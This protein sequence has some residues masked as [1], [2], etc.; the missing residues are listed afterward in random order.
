LRKSF[1]VVAGAS[2][3]FLPTFIV[4][5]SRAGEVFALRVSNCIMT[6]DDNEPVLPA[7]VVEEGA[8]DVIEESNGGKV[9]AYMEELRKAKDHRLVEEKAKHVHAIDDNEED[10]HSIVPWFHSPVQRQRWG[11]DQVLPH[12]NW[13][14]LFFD[15]FY[16]AAAYNLGAMLMSALNPDEWQRGVIYFI[17]IFGPI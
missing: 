5:K 9:V 15:L 7:V 3:Y 16:M 14:D 11:K 12:V 13:G 10:H 4:I 1:R 6:T 8:V 2:Y 17:G